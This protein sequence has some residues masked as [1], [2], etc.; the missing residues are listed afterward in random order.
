MRPDHARASLKLLLSR[1]S[2]HR[3]QASLQRKSQFVNY[4]KRSV[5]L[6]P[7]FK[8]LI[9]VLRRRGQE[10]IQPFV[11]RVQHATVT[12]QESVTAPLSEIGRYVAMMFESRGLMFTLRVAL[13]DDRLIIDVFGMGCGEMTALVVFRM[14]PDQE[15]SMR[16]FFARH[17]L[18]TPDDSGVPEQFNPALPVYNIYRVSPLPSE[19]PLLSELAADLFR[20]VCGLS[21]DAELRFH[22]AE[23]ADPAQPQKEGR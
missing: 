22:Y 10:S 9:D 23:Y 20:S 3:V 15:R 13:P 16:E 7:G 18:H 6:P 17:N 14:D 21:D 4:K 19:A 8:N 1:P 5:T 11:A 2:S 12:R